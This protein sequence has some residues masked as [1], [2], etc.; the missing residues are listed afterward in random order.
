MKILIAEDDPFQRESLDLLLREWGYDVVLAA[1]G[2]GA[3]K[4]LEAD[5]GPAVAL[6]DWQM[7]GLTG[8]EVCARMRSRTLRRPCHLILLTASGSSV[9]VQRGLD[10][11]A[12]DYVRKPFEEVELRARIR[13][14]LRSAS[15]EMEL[16]RRVQELERASAHIRT[17][18]GI[19]P[20]CS[21]CKKIRDDA[22][23]WCRMEEY[24]TA[25]SEARFSHSVCPGCYDSI[26]VPQLRAMKK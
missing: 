6:L 10:S 5:D 14:G 25:R 19:L 26:I 2:D 12:D 17:L 8:P 13:A 11:G 4:A 15:L 21:Y 24:I 3:L 9:D 7:P 23:H 22:D 20:V 1:D 16:S 18:E